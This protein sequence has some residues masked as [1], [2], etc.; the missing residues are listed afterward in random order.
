MTHTLTAL[1]A[2]LARV[3]EHST[4]K[5]WVFPSCSPFPSSLPRPRWKVATARGASSSS[6]RRWIAALFNVA[7]GAATNFTGWKGQHRNWAILV[8][9]P[10]HSGGAWADRSPMLRPP[11]SGRVVVSNSDNLPFP[12]ATLTKF[13][14]T[15]GRENWW[16]N[17]PTQRKCRDQ[18]AQLDED[19]LCRCQYRRLTRRCT[20]P[21]PPSQS[22]AFGPQPAT[23]ARE[24][25]LCHRSITESRFSSSPH[26]KK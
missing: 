25:R 19:V 3:P 24:G 11:P 18:A 4:S 12:P 26:R 14:A 13:T 8:H 15:C 17:R 7:S 2:A 21:I 6:S 20:P 23:T 5:V 1:L 22:H 9:T 10:Q 16:L